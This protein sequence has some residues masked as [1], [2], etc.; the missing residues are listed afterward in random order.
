MLDQKDKTYFDLS[1]ALVYDP[2]IGDCNTVQ[3]KVPTYSFAVNNQ[4]IINLNESVLNGMGKLSSTCGWEAV[5]S[6][7]QSQAQTSNTKH[8][9]NGLIT[10]SSTIVHE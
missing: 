6:D 8:R 7:G 5:S 2:C 4:V 9:V 1:G 10:D 3:M